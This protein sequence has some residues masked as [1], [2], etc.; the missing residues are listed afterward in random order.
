MSVEGVGTFFFG[1]EHCHTKEELDGPRHIRV[2]WADRWAHY[3]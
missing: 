1:T 3:G 2:A